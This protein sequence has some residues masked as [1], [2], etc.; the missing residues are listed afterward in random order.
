[1]SPNE[2]ASRNLLGDLQVGSHGRIDANLDCLGKSSRILVS[3]FKA[4]WCLIGYIRWR[5]LH[6]A[7]TSWVLHRRIRDLHRTIR[8]MY[9]V[10]LDV[11]LG[12]TAEHAFHRGAFLLRSHVSIPALPHSLRFGDVDNNVPERSPNLDSTSTSTSADHPA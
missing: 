4:S 11:P 2:G 5:G 3:L 10:P 7:A 9:S 1:M 12:F 8:L 6:S